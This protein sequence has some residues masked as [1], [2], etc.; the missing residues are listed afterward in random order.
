MRVMDRR[1]TA[2][3]IGD[4]SRVAA[5]LAGF[6]RSARA[7]SSPRLR[8]LERFPNQWVGIYNGRLVAHG[9]TLDAVLAEIDARG[10]PR[11]NVFVHF[12]EANH[13][14]LIV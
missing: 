9:P 5:N 12:V 3:L 2:E 6:R 8:L 11:G 14:T 13:R 10:L 7:L 4:I 1:P